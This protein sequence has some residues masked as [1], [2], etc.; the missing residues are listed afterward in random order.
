MLISICV[1]PLYPA[2]LFPIPSL[3]ETRLQTSWPCASPEAATSL[4]PVPSPRLSGKHVLP[5]H[6]I[7]WRP[8]VHV[9]DQQGQIY[10]GYTWQSSLGWEP[11]KSQS[12]ALSRLSDR[13][14]DFQ[15]MY[16]YMRPSTHPCA[17]IP[18][19]PEKEGQPDLS[20]KIT[21]LCHSPDNV[22]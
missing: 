17:S 6:P 11:R 16:I 13:H 8:P 1:S 2:S 15:T 9:Q 12:Y 7:H 22:P 5:W 19:S 20:W 18:A 3:S 10:R 14:D 21:P 4:T